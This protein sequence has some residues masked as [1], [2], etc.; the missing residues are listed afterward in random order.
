MTHEYKRDGDIDISSV[1]FSPDGRHIAVGG[2][3]KK[4]II[5]DA[6]TFEVL[7]E[8]DAGQILWTVAYILARWPIYSCGRV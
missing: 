7:H 5:P 1:A 4:I 3:E 8:C 6:S 2:I